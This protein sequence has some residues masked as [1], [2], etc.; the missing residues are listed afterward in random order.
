MPRYAALLRGVSPTNA[1]MADLK[2]CFEHAGFTNVKTVLSSG[3]VVFDALAGSEAQLEQEAE[4]A[5]H[6]P[7]SAAASP[8][9]SGP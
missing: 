7:R 3:N 4:A 9:T 1:K 5:M 8:P 6:T 2:R